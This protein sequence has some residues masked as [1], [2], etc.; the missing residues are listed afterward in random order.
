MT[1]LLAVIIITSLSPSYW[2]LRCSCRVTS[3]DTSALSPVTCAEMGDRE[4]KVSKAR[5]KLERFRKKKQQQS[6]DPVAG[7]VLEQPV[8]KSVAAPSEPL[9]SVTLAECQP[10]ES[11]AQQQHEGPGS[12]D[13]PVENATPSLAAYFAGSAAEDADAGVSF[14]NLVDERETCAAREASS[15][16]TPSALLQIE[17][18]Q[19]PEQTELQFGGR[20]CAVISHG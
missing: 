2:L 8:E 7:T 1:L 18:E 3:A 14:P 20:P 17:V 10:T 16:S 15:N 13:I 5:E 4:D 19:R 9:P 6:G 12:D 11:D